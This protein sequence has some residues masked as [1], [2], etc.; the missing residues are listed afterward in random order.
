VRIKDNLAFRIYIGFLL[1]ILISNFGGGTAISGSNTMVLE[2]FHSLRASLYSPV[3]RMFIGTLLGEHW[4]MDKVCVLSVPGVRTGLSVPDCPS[5]I[6]RQN[7]KPF[8]CKEIYVLAY[9]V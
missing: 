1:E 5:A 9:K 6:V 4:W 7:A 3:Y 2:L 8:R